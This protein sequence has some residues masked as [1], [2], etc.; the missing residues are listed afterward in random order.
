M[1]RGVSTV[2]KPARAAP[3]VVPGVGEDAAGGGVA[4]AG[5]R[6]DLGDGERSPEEGLE[7]RRDGA[8]GHHRLEASAVPAPAH[9][10]VAVT[11]VDGDV[12]DLA[13]GA[14]R[15][16]VEAPVEHQP[17]PDTVR[18]F[19]EHTVPDLAQRAP[20]LL[21]EGAEGGVVVDPAR[22]PEV[23]GDA[24][25]HRHPDPPRE[26]A[27]GPHRARGAVDGRRQPDHGAAQRLA[28]D[29]GL[30][31]RLVDQARRGRQALGDTVVVGQVRPQLV[32]PG[33]TRVPGG[34]GRVGDVGQGDPQVPVTDIDAGDHPRP[35]DEPDRSYAPPRTHLVTRRQQARGAEVPHDVRHRGRREPRGARDLRLRRRTAGADGVHHAAA[36]RVAQTGRAIRVAG[37]CS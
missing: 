33:R 13:R 21:G 7:Q 35:A 10:G 6:H 27:G 36:V 9:R 32:A 23:L 8:R 2:Q 37:P 16:P 30:R 14:V 12:A 3:D 24:A 5:A 15:A 31:E 25:G 19:E 11:R 4:V 17:G 26:H 22:D 18:E 20:A 28:P 29:A 1:R 34:R